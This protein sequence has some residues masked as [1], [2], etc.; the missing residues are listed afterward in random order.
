MKSEFFKCQKCGSNEVTVSNKQRVMA[1]LAQRSPRLAWRWGLV[2]IMAAEITEGP[3]KGMP[4]GVAWAM[5]AV[6]KS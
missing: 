5:D 2:G 1:W 4:L 6:R 3:D